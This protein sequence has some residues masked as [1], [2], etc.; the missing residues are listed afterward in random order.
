MKNIQLNWNEIVRITED[1]EKV[2]QGLRNIIFLNLNRE[3]AP[4]IEKIKYLF[5]IFFLIIGLPKKLKLLHNKRYLILFPA[6]SPATLDNLLPVYN[7]LHRE[8]ILI[9]K[10]KKV[11][12]IHFKEVDS[13]ISLKEVP[14]YSSYR[15]RFLLKKS[16]FLLRKMLFYKSDNSSFVN[17][18]IRKNKIKYLYYILLIL[19]AKNAAN[20]ILHNYKIKILVSSSDHFP[21]E[22]A[23]FSASNSLNI[24]NYVIQHGVFGLS[25]YP[26]TCRYLF[27]WN[28]FIRDEL[29][30]K[31]AKPDTILISGMPCTDTMFRNRNMI[32][33]KISPIKNILVLSDTQGRNIYPGVYECFKEFLWDIIKLNLKINIIIKLHPA[34]EISYYNEFKGKIQILNRSATLNSSLKLCDA[35]LTIWSTAGLQAMILNK[36]TFILDIHKDVKH[37]AWWP[38]KGGGRYLCN[39]QDLLSML[40]LESIKNMLNS[41]DNF[42]KEYFANS[43]NAAEYIYRIIAKREG[44]L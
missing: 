41:Q 20:N 14:F 13:L 38:K 29:I 22:Y 4:I 36:P 23:L 33:N 30:N 42:I 1:S 19:I 28:N 5:K 39:A 16:H 15:Q 26:F 10:H 27:V 2:L 34:E 24:N 31:G 11:D 21:I 12:N 32:D 18:I 6:N 3:K 35:V 44:I 43:G 40:N 17:S 8:D 7:N 37:Y 9:I 25:H